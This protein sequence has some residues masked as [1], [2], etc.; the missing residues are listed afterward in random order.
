MSSRIK[1]TDTSLDLSVRHDS[2]AYHVEELLFESPNRKPQHAVN[3][4]TLAGFGLLSALALYLLDY[5]GL[6][7]F[8][9]SNFFVIFPII[10]LLLIFFLGF[11]P[12]RGW[13]RRRARKLE[14]KKRKKKLYKSTRRFPVK[15]RKK[16]LSG[17]CGGIAQYLNM[18]PTVFRLLFMIFFIS[19]G[20]MV[21]LFYILLAIFMHSADEEA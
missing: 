1:E 11:A 16:Y 2:D 19:T 12:L 20:G 6:P 4:P 10:G 8:D 3:L 17:V 5:L 9:I 7:V 15:S 21:L 14:A 18:N 13:R